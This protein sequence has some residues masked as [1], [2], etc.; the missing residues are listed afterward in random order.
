MIHTIYTTN[1]K[2][3]I[4][5]LHT[6]YHNK[7][8]VIK[9]KEENLWLSLEYSIVCL[10][11]LLLLFFFS[12]FSFF[13]LFLSF[14]SFSLFFFFFFTLY[15]F[16]TYN[17]KLLI[18]SIQKNKKKLIFFFFSFFFSLF[19]S[20]LLFSYLFIVILLFNKRLAVEINNLY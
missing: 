7:M 16:Y 13:S 3:T 14:F 5:E 12:F 8:L 10:L 18:K 1:M 9:V 15:E 4:D 11:L 19:F 6:Y 20:F 2:T 17:L